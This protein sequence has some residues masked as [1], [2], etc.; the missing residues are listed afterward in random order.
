MQAE[1]RKEP[2]LTCQVLPPFMLMLGLAR[3]KGSA[4]WVG[5]FFLVC[6]GE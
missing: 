5:L 4:V 1:L 3:V 6:V 2:A